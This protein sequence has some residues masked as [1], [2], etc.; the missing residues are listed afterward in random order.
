MNFITVRC[1][2]FH[3]LNQIHEGVKEHM[4]EWIK[5]TNIDIFVA[6]GLVVALLW[7]MYTHDNQLSQTI[8]TGLI[9]YIGGSKAH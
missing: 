6:A 7:S 9:G 5:N 1:L 3:I 2:I 8:A 4:A